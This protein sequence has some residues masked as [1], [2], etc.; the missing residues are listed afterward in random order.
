MKKY[1]EYVNRYQEWNEYW[2]YFIENQLKKHLL[3]NQ[4]D[5]TEIEHILD[6]V[7]STKKSYK[8]IWYKT[9]LEK[10]KA[11]DKKLQ[12][13]ASKDV[14]EIWVD[15][16]VVHDFGDW[17]KFVKL[18]SQS[19]YNRE[20]KLMSHCVAGYYG[21]DVAIYSLRDENNKPHCT[22]EENNQVKW[23]WNQTVDNKYFSYCIKFL[24]IMG[25]SIWEN[26]MKNIGYY[27]LESIDED[28]IVDEKYLYNWKY[29]SDKNLEKIKD[30][31]WE[32]YNGF[33][34][35]NIKDV[36]EFKWEFDFKINFDI[37]PIVSYVINL[38]SRL[39]W[40]MKK[41]SKSDNWENYAQIGSS[42]YS[43][44]IGSSG[45]Y[46]KIGSSGYYA[47]IGSSGDSPKIGSSGYY[48]QIGSSGYYAKIGSSGDSAKIGSSGDSAQI[49]SSG[50]S[51]QIGSSGD[52]AQ[53][54]SS[55]DSA[56][57]GSSGDSA[58]IGSSGDSAK[59]G[60]SGDSA[61]I[62]S[63]GDYAKIWS[64][65]WANK[66]TIEWNKSVASCI[67]INSQ[68]KAKIGTWIVLAEYI[69]EKDKR[70]NTVYAPILV[71]TAIIDGVILKE[72][73]FYK[74]ENWEF[75]ECEE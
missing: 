55:G 67:G 48:A 43:P 7:Y 16:E 42:G 68:V 22:I 15:Y 37:A 59:I 64:V 11:R 47:Q 62:G 70:N 31:Y 2:L 54:G 25:F 13:L 36:V 38:V 23:K 17:F 12:A 71:K 65:W 3:T 34:L 26:E 57:I 1:I 35:L 61:Q 4:E 20:W 45:D 14:E 74:L 49:G 10:T 19:A 51:A 56:Q 53:I 28:L 41:S 8:N 30:K 21:R 72:N 32:Q 5:Q 29:I 73:T 46:A 39:I 9:I 33:W 44:K 69:K 63:S 58:Q 40:N 6:F 27:K 75:V 18:L 24:E 50:D 60:S 52:S 66:I